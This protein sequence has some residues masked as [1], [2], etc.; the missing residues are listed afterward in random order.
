MNSADLTDNGY[1]D[2]IVGIPAFRARKPSG[3]CIF[4]GGP[5][6]FDPENADYCVGDASATALSLADLNNDGHLDLMVGAYSSAT[7]RVLPMQIFWGT[8]RGLNLNHPTNIMA[9]SSC[10]FLPVDL[11]GN[12]YLDVLVACHRNDLGH[13]VDS[14]ILW[15]GPE[16]LSTER[17]TRLPGMG[18]HDLTTRDPGNGMDRKPCERYCS[19]AIDLQEQTP[20]RIHWEAHVPETTQLKFQLRG[21]E[22]EE[23]L[24]HASWIGVD[25]ESTYFEK[26]GQVIRGISST[27][28]WLQYRASFIS[29]DGCRSAQLREVRIDMCA[30]SH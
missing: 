9:D 5:D 14:M 23:A 11:T 25:G 2:L 17:V 22:S 1:L 7:T 24:N 8:G 30:G 26:S 28:Q 4:Y 27:A 20:L 29:Q 16:G 10:G 3:F 6:G 19:A 15:N 13:Q 21:A 18:P 12:G